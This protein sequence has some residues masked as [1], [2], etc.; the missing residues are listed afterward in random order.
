MGKRQSSINRL[1]QD[2]LEKLQELLCDPRIT[3]MD[4][5]IR[6]N[7]ILE[8]EGHPDRVS[9]SS[10]NRYD[11]EMRKVGEKLRQSREVANM[12]IG[13]LGAAPQGKL[14]NLINETLRTLAFD[15]TLKLNDAELTGESLPGVIDQL[16]GLALAAQRLEAGST[17]NV[18]REAEIRKQAIEDVAKTAS[19][20]ARQ[21]GVSEETIENIWRDVLRMK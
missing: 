18:K 5:T 21:A 14:G 11:M 16:K 8:A 7:E 9:K 4:A 1:P 13:K 15:A 10:V 20:A 17:M 2:I 19:E 12:W 6:I 3:Q